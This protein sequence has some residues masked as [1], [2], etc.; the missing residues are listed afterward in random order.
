MFNQTLKDLINS[1]GKT[2]KEIAKKTN[3]S[4]AAMSYYING[5]TEP[6]LNI[7]I[8]LADY[9]NVSMD[10]LVGREND[11]GLVEVKNDLNVKE[12]ELIS[13]Y[14]VLSPFEQGELVGAARAMAKRSAV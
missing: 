9:F 1:S 6:T 2:A 13:Y 14:R 5:K 11:Y 8:T 12:R 7:L 3:I 4:Q 10:Y